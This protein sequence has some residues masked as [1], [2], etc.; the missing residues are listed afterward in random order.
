MTQA[1][2]DTDESLRGFA[3][4]LTSIFA[5]ILLLMTAFFNILQGLSAISNDDLF[6]AGNEYLYQFNMTVWGSVHIIMGVV[7][8]PIA[9]GILKGTHWGRLAGIV[10]ASLS[11]LTNFAFLPHYPLWAMTIIAFDLL[12]IWALS[13]Q[14]RNDA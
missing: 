2:N 13:V 6:R 11:I 10:V 3:A 8:V 9:F 1:R 7:S 5:G 14:M 12:V 4:D